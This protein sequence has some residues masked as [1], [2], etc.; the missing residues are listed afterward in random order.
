MTATAAPAASLPELQ[1]EP[2]PAGLRRSRAYFP[3]LESLRGIAILLVFAYHADGV[4]A[5]VRHDA[6]ALTSF[7]RAGHT[8]VALFFILSGFLL[9]LPFLAE[10]D[11]GK[12]QSRREYYL[13]R[14]LRILP[15]YWTAVLVATVHSARSLADLNNTWPH[16]ILVRG[17]APQYALWPYSIGWWSL[18]T[19]V[20]FYL[21]L[22]LL[23]LLLRSRWRL[24]AALAVYGVVYVTFLARLWHLPSLHWQLELNS[25]LFGRLP[26]FAYGITAA[27]IYRTHGPAIRD[28]L[29]ASPWVRR[30]A[31]DVALVA[32]FAVLAYVLR[33]AARHG[34][35]EAEMPPRH[36]Y[37]LVEGGLWA[38]ILLLLLLAPL[39][40][41][42]LFSNRILGSIGVISFSLFIIHIPVL[43]FSVFILRAW[44]PGW[45]VAWDPASAL[46]IAALFI[47]CLAASVLT[48]W[49]IERPFLMRKA[50]LDR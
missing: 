49:A 23:P 25:N 27:W 16:L 2:Q 47:A 45:F 50:R 12:R 15:L 33:W 13:R 5:G 17:L 20:Q 29:A 7:V 34:F 8:G 41:K 39:R 19:E 6:T 44:Y 46:L 32:A 38:S 14:A 43:A 22:P 28:R 40:T 26:L 36:A 37:H 30:G 42:T 24:A 48:Y 10:A 1:P 31:A 9:S 3:E 4:I 11:G 35:W 18:G 21:V